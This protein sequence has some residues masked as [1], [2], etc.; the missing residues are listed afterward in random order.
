VVDDAEEEVLETFEHFKSFSHPEEDH[1]VKEL[2]KKIQSGIDDLPPRCREI[3]ILNR[4][5]GLTY[6]EIAEYLEIS[7]NTV[8]TQMGRALKS[9]RDHLSDYFQAVITAGITKLFF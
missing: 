3:F 6:Q 4:R 9:L 5:S 2:R 1:D 8:N 7:I